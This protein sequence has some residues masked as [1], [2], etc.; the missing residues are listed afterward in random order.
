MKKLLCLAIVLVLSVSLCACSNDERSTSVKI[1]DNSS[2]KISMTY[3]EAIVPFKS[4]ETL[5]KI[6]ERAETIFN[7]TDCVY[8]Y[9]IG[10]AYTG[11]FGPG[12]VISNEDGIGDSMNA[13]EE[14]FESEQQ[15]TDYIKTISNPVIKDS[16]LKFIDLAREIYQKFVDNPTKSVA[17]EVS[18]SITTLTLYKFNIDFFSYAN[19]AD[20]Y[21][22]IY[23]IKVFDNLAFIEAY[24]KLTPEEIKRVTSDELPED[25]R[26]RMMNATIQCSNIDRTGSAEGIDLDYLISTLDSLMML[27]DNAYA[28]AVEAYGSDSQKLAA[29]EDFINHA[30]KLYN[31]VRVHRPEFNDTEYIEKYKFDLEPLEDID[32]LYY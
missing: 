20:Y 13:L 31:T 15:Y 25:Y 12:N 2:S 6:Y 23:T 30:T 1:P 11:Q 18:T 32:A 28:I 24:C 5:K 16:Y 10:R 4:D 27:K 29:Y 7:H 19:R 17:E 14:Y 3:E 26:Y 8:S 22:T 21:L 9:Y